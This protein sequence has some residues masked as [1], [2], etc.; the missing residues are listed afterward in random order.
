MK[1]SSCVGRPRRVASALLL[2][3]LLVLLS[4]LALTTTTVDSFVVL[5]SARRSAGP[6]AR[7]V[8]GLSAA[9]EGGEINRMDRMEAIKKV[10]LVAGGW[11]VA[12][13]GLPQLV[14]AKK[15]INLEEAREL[16]E[17]KMIEIEK[18]KGPLIK[19]RGGVTHSQLFVCMFVK[20]DKCHSSGLTRSHPFARFS[21][22]LSTNPPTNTQSI[23]YETTSS[24][25]RS[26]LAKAPPL[27]RAT[28]SRSAT[29]F[30]K[31]TG[32]ICLARATA[33][34]S[35][36]TS[37]VRE[38]GRRGGRGRKG[39]R[40]CSFFSLPIHFRGLISSLPPPQIPTISPSAVP[41]PSPRG[42]RSGWR[43]CASEGN[44]KFPCRLSWGGRPREGSRSLSR[45]EGR[46]S[47]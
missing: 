28:W 4:L 27:N 37:E 7:S 30:I 26:L 11:G 18:A 1:Q 24:T 41:T 34:S 44:V 14:G 17:K 25:A 39:G 21:H 23:R 47:S 42:P 45:L 31:E 13:A 3:P 33:A 29:R 9:R 10:G 22:L 20:A 15:I 38:G 16:G 43:A 46:G 5:P 32:T 8:Q 6:P 2:P 12:A 36:M 19:V 40:G 35:R